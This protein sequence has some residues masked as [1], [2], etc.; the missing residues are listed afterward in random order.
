MA[1]GLLADPDFETLM[2][3]LG[4]FEARPHVAVAVSGGADSLC[5]ALL[6]GRWA[7]RFG[8]HVTALTVDH[9][10]RDQS[11]AEA[12]QVGGWLTP[13]GIDH[14][15]LAWQGPK[16]TAGVQALA[17]A[18]RYGLMQAWCR[19][20]GVLHIALA[21]TR[22][23]QAETFLLRLGASSGP[24]G[25]AAMSAVREVKDVRLLRPLLSV[26]KAALQATLTAANQPW[27]DDPSNQDAV[28]ARVRVRQAIAEGGLDARNLA[29]SADRFAR[30]RQTLEAGAAALLARALQTNPAGFAVLDRAAFTDADDEIS[31]RALARVVA[32]IGGRDYG[33][34]WG[35]LE[36][37]HRQLFVDRDETAATLGGCRVIV[38]DGTL[39]VCRENRDL[40]GPMAVHAGEWLRWDRRFDIHFGADGGHGAHGGSARLMALGEQGWAEIVGH[41]PELRQQSV[42]HP[43]KASLPALFDEKGVYSVPHLGFRR[44]RE[45]ALG[46]SQ[47]VE[48]AD[49]RFSPPNSFS[50]TGFF[51]H[52][53]PDI[54]SL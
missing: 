46:P 52:I 13:H 10:L 37:L 51:L 12:V 2:A 22:D 49:I 29:R 31:L 40:P 42:P 43:V 50:S 21:H 26:P 28:Y 48:I 54:L 14:H 30:V 23:D 16:P 15:I 1:P 39:L 20:H 33:P 47:G 45:G 38:K 41:Q 25:L 24:D 18:A 8:G 17:R 53:E 5:L 27:I 34:R 6:A 19:E 11:A 44:L 7:K 9:G 35:R 32:A 4:P 36:R 3:G